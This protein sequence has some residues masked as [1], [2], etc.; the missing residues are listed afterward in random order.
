MDDEVLRRTGIVGTT[1][2]RVLEWAK[3]CERLGMDGVLAS[4][5]E[6]RAIRHCCGEDFLI[7]TSGIRSAEDARHD[8]VRVASAAEAVREG[9]DYIVVGRAVLKAADPMAAMLSICEEVDSALAGSGEEG[10]ELTVDEEE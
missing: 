5:H 10:A 3:T 1:H 8:Q 2:Q 6:A 4:A 7:V 9:A